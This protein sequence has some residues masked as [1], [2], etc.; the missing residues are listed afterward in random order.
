MPF[1]YS[2]SSIQ[3]TLIELEKR[4]SSILNPGLLRDVMPQPVR[5]IFLAIVRLSLLNPGHSA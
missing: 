5:L 3:A 1:L 4:L 2:A